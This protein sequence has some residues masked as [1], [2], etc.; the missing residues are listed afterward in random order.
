MTH[1]K[2]YRLMLLVMLIAFELSMFYFYFT[3]YLKPTN[4]LLLTVWDL[5]F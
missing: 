1:L 2:C 4:C 3:I 5:S